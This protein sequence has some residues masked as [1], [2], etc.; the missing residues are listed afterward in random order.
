ME[1]VA[2]L[3]TSLHSDA[4]AGAEFPPLTHRIAYLFD[5]WARQ[6]Q[7]HPELSSWSRL[8]SLASQVPR[9]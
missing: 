3:V 8:L 1:S 9:S 7:L 6:R 5:S 2:E 4:S